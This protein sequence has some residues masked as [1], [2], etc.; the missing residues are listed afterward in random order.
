M[1][2]T[3]LQNTILTMFATVYLHTNLHTVYTGASPTF[4]HT[5]FILVIH[6]KLIAE[7]KVHTAATT[8]S[9]IMDAI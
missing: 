5:S 2:R 9:I 7:Y 4:V 3:L 1:Y 6:I 8:T